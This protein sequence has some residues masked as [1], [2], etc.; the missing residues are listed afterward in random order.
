MNSNVKILSQISTGVNMPKKMY[1]GDPMYF[2]KYEG[3]ELKRLTYAKNFR[4]K[5]E[6]VGHLSI[7]EKEDSFEFEGK[8]VPFKEIEFNISLAPNEKLLSIFKEGKI[9]HSHKEKSL[10]IGVDSARYVVGVDDR[11]IEINTMGDGFW[12]MV[13]EVYQGGKLEGILINLATGEYSEFDKVKSDLE[14]LFD[15]KFA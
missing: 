8:E 10:D 14:Y 6:W 11:E 13:V 2:D 4:G 1:V 15:I 12:G 5:S 3:S 7:I 9:L